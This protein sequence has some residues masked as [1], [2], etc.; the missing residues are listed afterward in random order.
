MYNNYLLG[1]QEKEDWE[2][3]DTVKTFEDELD[4]K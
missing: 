4:D 2:L 3:T 1:A